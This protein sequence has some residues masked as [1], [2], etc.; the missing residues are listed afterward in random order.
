MGPNPPLSASPST[1]DPALAVLDEAASALGLRAWAVGGYVRDYLLGRPHP[2]LD[3]VVEGDAL[4][5]AERF[6]RLT[7]SR[8]PALFPRFGTAQVTW[9]D[10]LVEFASA[11]AESYSPDSR[12]P[13]VRPAS[14]EDDLLRR[15]F[16]VN[17]LLMDFQGRVHDPLGGRADLERRLLRTPRD[18]V[19]TFND[20][21]LRMLR[22]IRLAAQL[23][24]ELD[25][26]LPPAIRQL[27]DR[28]RPP[29]LSVERTKDEL[30][31]ILVSDR[32]RRALELLD[33][34]GLME[35]L[36]PEVFACHGVE[37]GGWHTH[38]VFG[39]SLETV[40]H[41]QAD[42]VL[43]LAALLHDVGK[44]STA[45]PDGAFHGHDEV[46]AEVARMALVRLRFSNA[47]VDAVSRL[48]RL[49][50]RPVFYSSSWGDGAVRRLAREA[51]D[52]LWKLLELARADIAASAYPHGDKLDELS[53]R[54]REVLA[55]KPS[56]MRIPVT[57][58][59][60]MAAR[61]I[62]PGPQ[63]GHV[64]SRLEE[65]VLDGTLAPERAAL[66][67]YLREHPDL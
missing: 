45:T 12:K 33:S 36:L 20:D 48:V 51:G 21:P 43:R 7:G 1:L 3:V 18:P 8:R 26:G 65:L 64:K 47:E 22:A 39:H 29:V 15:D 34:T 11:R 62:G 25:A 28:A 10:R 49:H 46:G 13:E 50:L 52:L 58:R 9:G 41:T 54:L 35:A 4:A 19:Q 27:R 59:D 56:R 37:Q 61:G 67:E 2:D 55:E 53:R 66:L 5:L 31:K 30:A 42:L 16:T 40:E 17:T 23:G 24:F 32:P 6:A 38:D 44:P 60:I 63:V 57:G 14:L